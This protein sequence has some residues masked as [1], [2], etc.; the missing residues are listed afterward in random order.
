MKAATT[1]V[2]PE[3]GVE[4]GRNDGAPDEGL[5]VVGINVEAVGL[6][7]GDRVDGRAV[8]VFVDGAKEGEADVGM[9]VGKALG[10]AVGLKDG[11]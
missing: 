3:V 9:N 11:L 4:V 5:D 6:G 7:E 8:G 1:W 10:L 2:L